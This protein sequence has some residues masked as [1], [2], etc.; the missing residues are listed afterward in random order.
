MLKTITTPVILSALVL[1][2]PAAAYSAPQQQSSMRPQSLQNQSLTTAPSEPPVIHEPAPTAVEVV[3]VGEMLLQAALAQVG[4][5]QDCTDLVQN[6]LAALGLTT[7]R[8]AGGFD[9][10]V[11]QLAQ[12]GYQVPSDQAQPGDIAITGPDNGG[13]VWIVLDPATNT[14]VHGG[15]GG[16]T[17]VGDGGLALQAH[18]VYR[19][20]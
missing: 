20:G 18:A 16:M 5:A 3:Q 15:W 6:S 2:T 9:Y 8:D 1:G 10:G 14:G 4:V 12:F 11:Q 17:V 19:V 7:R 13:H